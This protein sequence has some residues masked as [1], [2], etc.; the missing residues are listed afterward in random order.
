MDAIFR[1]E[2][3]FTFGV[4]PQ[5]VW[6]ALREVD[7]WTRWWPWLERCDVAALRAGEA[8]RARIRAPLGYHLDV[9]VH[10]LEVVASRRIVATVA[11]DL[12]GP[13]RLELRPT[14]DGCQARTTWELAVQGS[15]ASTLATL[16][17]PMVERGHEQVV[18][19][20]REAFERVLSGAGASDDA[21]ARPT[22]GAAESGRSDA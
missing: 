12:A 6:D 5:G 16:G 22:A 9:E 21:G 13:A 1:H 14:E 4:P 18:A 19:Q 3:A 17:R 15:L 11:G 2:H 10:L 8:A 7:A 20:G